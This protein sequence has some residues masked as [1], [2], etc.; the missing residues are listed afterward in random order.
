[1]RKKMKKL[2]ATTMAITLGLAAFSGCGPAGDA[3]HEFEVQYFRA[4]MGLQWLLDM[5]EGFEEKYPGYVVR[6][7][8]AASDV[9]NNLDAG[10][11]AVTAD[12]FI[13]NISWFMTYKDYLEPLDDILDSPAYNGT[14]T[15]R[16]KLYSNFQKGMSRDGKTYAIGWSNVPCGIFYNKS[17][18]DSMNYSEPRTTKELAML[19]NTIKSDV[20]Q[21]KMNINGEKIKDIY[22]R[23][24]KPTPFIHAFGDAPYWMYAWKAWMAQYDGLESYYDS[25]ATTWTNPETGEKEFPS[26]NSMFTQGRYEAYLALEECITPTGNTYERSNSLSHTES[27]TYFL[28]GEALMTPCGGWL[29]NEMRST[30]TPYDIALMKTPVLSAVGT[31]LGITETQLREIVSYVDSADYQT[32]TVNDASTEYKAQIVNAVKNGTFTGADGTSYTGAEIIAEIFED[33]NIMQ[34][35]GASTKMI[36]PNYSDRKDEVKL[37]LQYMYSDEGLKIMMEAQHLPAPAEFEDPSNMPDTSNW[38]TFAK[39]LLDFGQNP[40]QFIETYDSKFFRNNNLIM[41]I[42]Q[43]N[44]ARE[45]TQISAS[46]RMTARDIWLWEKD[47][48]ETRWGDACSLAVLPNIYGTIT[49]EFNGRETP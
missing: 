23:E 1:M 5:K 13:G 2:F 35:N 31:K 24:I 46:S 18:F 21:N 16:E 39:G 44:P 7:E 6:I 37:F 25:M 19:A 38:S 26:I 15:I 4:G 34:N 42:Y 9:G 47:Y 36:V 14:K 8:D 22:G 27:Q 40:Y 29:E 28:T 17:A 20:N 33:R 11:T 49:V 30:K 12:L 3:E 10:A 48:C 41:W 45:M 32:N 43:K